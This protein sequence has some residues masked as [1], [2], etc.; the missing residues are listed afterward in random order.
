M[1]GLLVT[2]LAAPALAREV[3][4]GLH[5]WL[6]RTDPWLASIE[7]F[8]PLFHTA[9]PWRPADWTDVY[10]FWGVLG[11]LSPLLLPLGLWRAWRNDARIGA[12]FAG[13]TLLLLALTLIQNRFGRVFCVNLALASGLAIVWLAER[14]ASALA[15]KLDERPAQAADRSSDARVMGLVLT[16]FIALLVLADPA[17]RE[18]L[19]WADPR[20]PSA[21][22]SAWLYIAD[23]D[24]ESDAQGGAGER[25]GVLAPW[26]FGHD[27]IWLADRGVLA[28]GFGPWTGAEAFAEL[29]GYTRSDEEALVALM[30]ERRIDYVV[31]GAAAFSGRVAL[32]GAPYP[33]ARATDASAQLVPS[34]FSALPLSALMLG[35][36]GAPEIG[37]PHLE[38]MRPRF[39]SPQ[40]VPGLGLALPVIWVYDRV[41]GARLRGHAA[42]GALVTA[43]I[44][45]ESHGQPLPYTAWTRADEEGAWSLRLPLPSGVE[46]TALR[47]APAYRVEIEGANARWLP[48]GED[49]V[50]QGTELALEEAPLAMLTRPADR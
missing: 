11:V 41:E 28:A 20:A 1:A 23:L 50:R 16:C 46:E 27:A 15:T 19:V 32:P 43:R 34:Y 18:R 48:V 13:W 47:T 4:G 38:H 29:E 37:V 45:I 7:E 25:G 5:E 14:T 40:R 22:E 17:L 24:G 8:Q 35:G 21:A 6:A 49:A 42:P 33:F 30:E 31:S 2:A 3:S 26:D 9:L 36:S 10:T 12:T 44:V 39:A